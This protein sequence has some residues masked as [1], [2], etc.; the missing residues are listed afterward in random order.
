[1]RETG[2]QI[3]DAMQGAVQGPELISTRVRRIV[4][5]VEA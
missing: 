5:D 4:A 1:M 3:L 2:Q